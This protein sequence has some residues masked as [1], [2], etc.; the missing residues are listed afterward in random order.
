MLITS[1]PGQVLS[2]TSTERLCV[3]VCVCVSQCCV[4]VCVCVCE[5]VLCVCVC[6]CVRESQCCVCV[7]VHQYEFVLSSSQLFGCGMVM[8]SEKLR[9]VGGVSETEA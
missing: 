7:C 2:I 4:C 9:P 3:C 6:V 5:S 1:R 8:R